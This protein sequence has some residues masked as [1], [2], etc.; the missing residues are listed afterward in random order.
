VLEK[1]DHVGIAVR[2]LDDAIRFYGPALGLEVVRIEEVPEQQTRVAMLP[3]GES[4]IELLEAMEGNSPVARSID[5]RGE[6]VHHLCFQ[7]NNLEEAL[8]RL[9]AAGIRM[10]DGYPRRGAG[11]CLVAFIHPSSASGVLIELSQPPGDSGSGS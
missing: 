2:N 1:I 10:V 4:R 6:G 7:V 3:V 8:V 9:R 11:G 5:V